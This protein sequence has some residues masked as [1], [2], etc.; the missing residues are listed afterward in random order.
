VPPGNTLAAAASS[1]TDVWGVQP[2]ARP[3]LRP[4][5]QPLGV[6]SW[7][8]LSIRG[9]P[10]LRRRTRSPA[11][12]IRNSLRYAGRKEHKSIAAACR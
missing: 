6:L 7:G 11:R 2:V 3:V 8:V 10:S 4:G 5:P 1:Y 9:G 12:L